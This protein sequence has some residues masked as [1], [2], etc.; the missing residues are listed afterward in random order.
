MDRKPLH[1]GLVSEERDLLFCLSILSII[2]FHFFEDVAHASDALPHALV[3]A[4]R[5]YNAGFG[6]IGVEIFALLSGVGIYF[7]LSKDPPVG[8]FYRRRCTRLLLPYALIGGTF[9]VLRDGVILKQ[10]ILHI[11]YDFSF[12]SFFTRGTRTVWYVG[13]QL[14][15]YILAPI[16]YRRKKHTPP[17]TVVLSVCVPLLLAVLCPGLVRNTEIALGR[18]LCFFAG[19]S[20]GPAV[21]KA[22]KVTG[23]HVLTCAAAAVFL[24]YLM[25]AAPAP[26]C[27]LLGRWSHCAYGICLILAVCFLS[28]TAA[29]GKLLGNGAAGRVIKWFSRYSLEIYLLHVV[30]RNLFNLIGWGTYQISSYIIVIGLSLP[31]APAVGRVASY[32]LRADRAQN[33]ETAG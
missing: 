18:I 16:V 9:W 30:I 15:L 28:T 33:S 22:R 8:D 3:L 26:V 20:M 21:L 11:L 31:L 25:G 23:W 29:A 14:F 2:V 24:Y 13:F 10:G 27:F 19:M 6:S 1:W 32:A 4:A 12:L 17:L 5:V 7:S